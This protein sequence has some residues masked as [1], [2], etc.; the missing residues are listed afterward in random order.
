MPLT[1][2]EIRRSKPKEKP[3]TL[4]DGNGLSI[5]IEP[6]GAKGW[7]FR[8]RFGGK[9]KMISFGIYPIVSLAEARTKRD[10]ARKLVAGGINPSDV[11]KSEKISAANLIENT[12][13]NITREW[14]EKRKD[15]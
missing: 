2:I 10:E 1:D 14:Y 4:N 6:N 9:P 13:E 11:R 7:R 5:L 3:Y 12:F 8:Y 15:R